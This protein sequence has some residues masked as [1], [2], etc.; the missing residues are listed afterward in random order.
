MDSLFL[1][2]EPNYWNKATQIHSISLN[3]YFNV[4]RTNDSY[5]PLTPRYNRSSNPLLSDALLEKSNGGPISKKHAFL[6][7]E[8]IEFSVRIRERRKKISFTVGEVF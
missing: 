5:L 7:E 8:K 2:R 6:L 1:T 4:P 3:T